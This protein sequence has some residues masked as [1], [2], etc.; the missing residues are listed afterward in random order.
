MS[1]FCDLETKEKILHGETL[2]PEQLARGK[3]LDIPNLANRHMLKLN[4]LDI[5]NAH[6]SKACRASHQLLLP[7]C[8]DNTLNP[9]VF[10]N[11]HHPLS[12]TFYLLQ[13]VRENLLPFEDLSFAQFCNTCC[14][15]R[16]LGENR[17]ST[18]CWPN[19]C[20]S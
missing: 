4:S 19:W 8:S 5:E 15:F 7:Q 3:P 16:K 14:R 17:Y 2:P 6:E 12:R 1:L 10:A 18:R 9:F 13:W 20:F 11:P